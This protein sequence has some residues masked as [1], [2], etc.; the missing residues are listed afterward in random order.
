M[1]Q[2]AK[3]GPSKTSDII[4]IIA[5]GDLFLDLHLTCNDLLKTISLLISKICILRK[6]LWWLLLELYQTQIK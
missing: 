4:E 6:I 1:S 2:D 5:M 3:Y